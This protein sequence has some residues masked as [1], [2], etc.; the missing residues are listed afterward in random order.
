MPFNAISAALA[1]VPGRSRRL[2]WLRCSLEGAVRVCVCATRSE[3]MPVWHIA[4]FLWAVCEG[5]RRH[6]RSQLDTNCRAVPKPRVCVEGK[7]AMSHRGVRARL[8]F[9]GNAVSNVVVV[10]IAFVVSLLP[11]SVFA[12]DS[13]KRRH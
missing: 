12:A 10:V 11:C 2:H 4:L 7:Q 6:F 1:L 9:P 8:R 5:D 3:V 13:A